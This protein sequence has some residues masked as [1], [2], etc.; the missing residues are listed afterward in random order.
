MVTNPPA[1]TFRDC[2]I[3]DS[4]VESPHYIARSTLVFRSLATIM[5]VFEHL[6]TEILREILACLYLWNLREVSRVSRFFNRIT[7]PFLYASLGCAPGWLTPTLRTLIARPALTRH[8][9]RMYFSRWQRQNIPDSTDSDRFSAMARERGLEMPW[10]PET[11]PWTNADQP[12]VS[13]VLALLI[14]HMVP[15]LQVLDIDTSRLL[16]SYL[17]STLTIPIE[18][19]PFKFL[20]ILKFG[21]YSQDS[22]VTPPMLLAMMR[23]PSLRKVMVDLQA[24]EN[25]VHD[26]PGTLGSIIAFAGQSQVTHLSLHFG[27]NIRSSTLRHMLQMPRALTHFSYEDDWLNPY[28][29]DAL[30]FRD[31]LRVLRHTLVSLSIGAVRALGLGEPAAQTIGDFSDWPLLTTVKCTMTGLLG[32]RATATDR[33]VDLLPMGIREFELR[34]TDGLSD[35]PPDEEWTASDMTNQMFDVVRQRPELMVVTVDMAYRVYTAELVG[36][37]WPDV[38]H[39]EMGERLAVASGARDVSIVVKPSVW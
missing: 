28:Q 17:E 34:R 3:G 39:A 32:T 21:E 36:K 4:T 30:P 26:I 15:N 29:P 14:L 20:R 7:E 5:P 13:E 37:V 1:K 33:V 35:L 2:H 19:L 25:Y 27:G 6:P 11:Q 16:P 8:V 24:P 22:R 31:A 10:S 9:R 18:S 38:Y 23:F 12:W